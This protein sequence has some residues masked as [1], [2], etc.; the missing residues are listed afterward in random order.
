M[1]LRFK[2]RE[3][4][5]QLIS[6]DPKVYCKL[7]TTHRRGYGVDVEALRDRFPL[8]QS[9]GEGSKMRSRGYRRLRWWKQFS[10]SPLIF[11]GYM[12]IYRR[13]MYVGGRLRGPRGW[14]RAQ[15]Q[16]AC[17]VPS[18][19]PRLFLDFHSKSSGSRLFQKSRSRRFHSVW[20]PFNIPFLRN[21]EISKKTAIRAGPPVS[22]LVPKVI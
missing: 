8:R 11:L 4:A 12:G 19:L 17:R 16:G 21:T 2:E 5:I 14:G 3:E 13:K 6:M 22:R 10:S 9:A 20:T 7:L 1:V 18:W 15:P